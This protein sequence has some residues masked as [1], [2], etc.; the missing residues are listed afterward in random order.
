VL[1]GGGKLVGRGAGFAAGDDG[2][3]A[4]DAGCGV[5][6]SVGATVEFDVTLGA[7]VGVEL[8]AGRL[9]L[10]QAASNE[11]M[12]STGST[13]LTLVIGRRHLQCGQALGRF[14]SLTPR[15]SD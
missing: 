5:G 7:G 15:T 8:R 11:P 9:L 2:F 12:A 4:G 3:G 14:T 10:P 1:W 6:D 13:L